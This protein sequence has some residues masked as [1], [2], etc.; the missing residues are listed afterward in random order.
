MNAERKSRKGDLPKRARVAFFVRRG[1]LLIAREFVNGGMN[2]VSVEEILAGGAFAV[3]LPW[4]R[5]LDG[6]IANFPP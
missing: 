5:P 1:S 2:A 3:A 4:R 6:D